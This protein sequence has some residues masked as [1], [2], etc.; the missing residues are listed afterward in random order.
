MN[1]ERKEAFHRKYRKVLREVAAQLGL[2]KGQF[3]V[4]SNKGGF[5]ILGEVRLYTD[6]FHL[7]L[8]GSTVAP[9][10]TRSDDERWCM[11]REVAHRRDYSGMRN[12]WM[13][14]DMFEPQRRL[15]LLST[16]RALQERP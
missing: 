15:S 1:P 11:Y 9:G 6:K 2:T 5:G 10:M 7:Q 14:L 8:G 4:S 3:E 16:L 12:Q 13:S